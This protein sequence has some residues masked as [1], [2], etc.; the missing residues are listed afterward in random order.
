MKTLWNAGITCKGQS[1]AKT[2]SNISK[3]QRLSCNGSRVQ[4]D[5][6][7]KVTK[8]VNDIV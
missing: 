3:V 7:C 4:V 8:L 1:A 5:S 2:N 6:K